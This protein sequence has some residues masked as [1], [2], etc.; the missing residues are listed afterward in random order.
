MSMSKPE[1]NSP[2]EHVKYYGCKQ[3][4]FI[5]KVF[6]YEVVFDAK[7]YYKTHPDELNRSLYLIFFD[8]VV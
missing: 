6:P 8:Q 5:S 3:E 7:T 2:L 1:E 4:Y